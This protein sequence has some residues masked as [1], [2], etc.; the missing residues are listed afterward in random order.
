MFRSWA[1]PGP[2]LYEARQQRTTTAAVASPDNPFP[3]PA[4]GANP[5]GHADRRKWVDVFACGAARVGAGSGDRESGLGGAI[6]CEFF[7]AWG[8]VL[9]GG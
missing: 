7:G 1:K 4:G 5:E 2:R 3:A 9:A 8:F 6:A